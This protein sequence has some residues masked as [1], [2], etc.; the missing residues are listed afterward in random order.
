[1]GTFKDEKVAK[2][3]T[4]VMGERNWQPILAPDFA[5]VMT[6]NLDFLH[7][8][9]GL[10]TVIAVST[11]IHM[12]SIELILKQSTHLRFLEEGCHG[13]LSPLH[14]SALSLPS[15]AQEWVNSRQYQKEV[16][17]IDFF[18]HL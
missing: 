12:G 16:N 13:S 18:I 2:N 1:V 5:P 10:D 17:A 15:L 6:S 9:P 3:P 7:P 11:H 14:S 8:G 4:V